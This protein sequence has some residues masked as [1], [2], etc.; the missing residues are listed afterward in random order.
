MTRPLP[1]GISSEVTKS[2]TLPFWAVEITFATPL[3]L[4]GR[5]IMTIG[6]DT[7]AYAGLTVNRDAGSISI[8][9]EN[10]QFTSTFRDEDTAGV[11][12]RVWL[13]YGSGG[14]WNYADLQLEID[15][16]MGGISI[17]SDIGILLRREKPLQTPRLVV[18][19]VIS[20]KDLIADGAIADTSSGKYEL[21]R[22]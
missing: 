3:R 15:G 22:A 6:G 14:V 21:T 13:G 19:D 9:N 11:R 4:C 12:A 18:G 10:A 20:E 2:R 5:E 17:G 1:S 7:F 8:I 16:E